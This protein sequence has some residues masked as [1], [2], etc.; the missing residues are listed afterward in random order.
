MLVFS[1]SWIHDYFSQHPKFKLLGIVNE[2]EMLLVYASWFKYW[3]STSKNFESRALA[4]LF[5]ELLN[6]EIASQSFRHFLSQ[7]KWDV[8]MIVAVQKRE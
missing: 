8:D 2:S 3:A 1:S 7:R 4:K 5:L 6:D